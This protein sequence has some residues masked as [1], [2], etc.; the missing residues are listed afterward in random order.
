MKVSV[1]AKLEVGGG[2]GERRRRRWPVKGA[3][4]AGGVTRVP[5]QGVAGVGV[6][7]VAQHPGGGDAE[8]DASVVL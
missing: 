8:R 7:V 1:P 4:G 5:G 6:G 3:G 2:V